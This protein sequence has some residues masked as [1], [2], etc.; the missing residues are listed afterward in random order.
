MLRRLAISL[1]VLLCA[2]ACKAEPLQRVPISVDHG[3]AAFANKPLN[4]PGGDPEVERA[5]V[6]LHGVRRNPADYFR[7]AQRLASDVSW[8]SSHTLVLAPGFFTA[9]DLPGR[10]DLPLWSKT[11]MQASP[12]VAGRT[13]ITPVQALDELL[14]WLGDNQ[15]YP[16]LR[17][18]ILMG[19]SAGGQ[20]LQRYAVFGRADLALASRGI[21]VRYV[22]SSP[23]SYLYFD[24]RR[25]VEGGFA[26]AMEGDCPGV[27][28]YRYGLQALPAYLD[29]GLDSRQLFQRYARRDITYLVGARDNDPGH[30]LLDRSCA[31]L[32]QGDSRLQRQ[33][34]YLAYERQ[35]SRDWHLPLT[36]EHG[37]IP[38]V[39]H[40]AKTLYQAKEALEL[41][42]D[43]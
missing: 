34:N 12:S 5:V 38:G 3:L 40:S 15:H 32:A 21:K 36:R 8:P 7:I 16:H 19:H 6:I 9:R 29:S 1:L 22:I 10:R 4:M 37:E 42:K 26:Q 31:A 33:R 24:A 43:E 20:L 23:S 39:G 17:H 28:R 18:I 13:G 35:L 11:W 2:C 30:P 27:D 14:T 25:A 41:F